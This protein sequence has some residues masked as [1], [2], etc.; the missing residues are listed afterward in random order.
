SFHLVVVQ[1]LVSC[2]TAAMAADVSGLDTAK[3]E[4]LT[5]AKGKMSEKEGVFKV[6]MP[7]S[8]L[9]VSAGG[10]KI[11]PPMGLTC[12]AAFKGMGDHAVMMGDQVLL[13]DQVNPV[14]S[15]ALDNGLQITALHNHFAGDNPRVMFM[16]IGGMGDAAKLAEAVG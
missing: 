16:H 5:G 1:A 3:I 9:A 15:V 14:M 2:S 13:E 12:W 10:V 11:T 4:Q 8:D 7:R 6:S